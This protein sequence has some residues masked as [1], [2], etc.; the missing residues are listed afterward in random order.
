MNFISY[1]RPV[2]PASRGALGIAVAVLL[3][4]WGAGAEAHK[5]TAPVM[6]LTPELLKVRDDLVKYKDPFVAVDTSLC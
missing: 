5:H 1:L 6:E 3:S 2:G 4:L